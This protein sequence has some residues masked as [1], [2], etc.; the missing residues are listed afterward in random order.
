MRATI[1][2]TSTFDRFFRNMDDFLG[3][4]RRDDYERFWEL[5]LPPFAWD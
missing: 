4:G 3:Y 2:N 5:D 1:S